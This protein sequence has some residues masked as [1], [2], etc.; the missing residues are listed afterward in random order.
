MCARLEHHFSDLIKTQQQTNKIKQKHV[1][2]K[3]KACLE[4]ILI[5]LSSQ[6]IALGLL[7]TERILNLY[8]TYKKWQ[9]EEREKKKNVPTQNSNPGT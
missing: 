1:I 9:Q 6:L 5:L 4:D 8:V 2:A 3:Q 7:T